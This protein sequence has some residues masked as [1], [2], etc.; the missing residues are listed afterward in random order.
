MNNH[1]ILITGLGSSLPFIGRIWTAWAV[2]LEKRL[3]EHF[4]GSKDVIITRV[5][6]DLRGE[7]AALSKL[8]KDKTNDRLGKVCIV[9]HSNGF[10]DGLN[11]SHAIG[12]DTPIDYFAGID[13]TLGELGAKAYGNI[14]LFHEFHAKLATAN[15]DKS[16]DMDNHHIW[17]I[18]KGHTAA[19]SDRFVQNKIFETITETIK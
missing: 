17:Q 8:R 19:A 4:K 7:D 15:F 2:K 16:F 10:R 3:K 9:G 5:S 12:L 13:M 11:I 1:V 6:A 18:N 14:Q